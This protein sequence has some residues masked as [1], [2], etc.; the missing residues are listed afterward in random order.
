MKQGTSNTTKTIASSE[1]T[2]KSSTR[3]SEEKRT[4]TEKQM[5]GRASNSE[6]HL[7]S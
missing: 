4:R 7:Q 2:N 6:L 3:E 5:Q 1:T